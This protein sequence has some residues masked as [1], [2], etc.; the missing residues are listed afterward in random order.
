MYETVAIRRLHRT[1]LIHRSVQLLLLAL[2]IYMA[3]HFQ[4][5]FQG[6][7]TPHLLRNSLLATMLLQF[8]L[9]FP[10]RRFAGNEARRE[11]AAA[12]STSAE[13]Q[14]QLRQQRLFGDVIKGAVFIGFT[15]FILIAP[16][17]TFVLSTAFFC[18]I[19]T[20]ITYLQCFGFALRRG[21]AD[22]SAAERQRLR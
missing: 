22:Q 10:L 5:I 17:A 4:E 20:V 18:F 3:M 12:A 8:A 19:V 11:L 14:K 2:L 7:G 13:Q 1:L 21:L 16:P 9:F 6:K 15:A